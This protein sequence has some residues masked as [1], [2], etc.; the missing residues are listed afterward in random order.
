MTD[1]DV[2]RDPAVSRALGT[3]AAVGFAGLLVLLLALWITEENL[4]G[5]AAGIVAIATGVVLGLYLVR[6]E[7][8]AADAPEL[9]EER[10]EP[11]P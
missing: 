4:V 5:T 9:S 6:S 2:S 10:T 3:A 8:P 1:A 7:P 11:T